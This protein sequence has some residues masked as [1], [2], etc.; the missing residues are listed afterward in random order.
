M[1]FQ[2]LQFLCKALEIL[3][4]TLQ[5]VKIIM[6]SALPI[7]SSAPGIKYSGY[8]FNIWHILSSTLSD[9][10]ST[11]SIMSSVPGIMLCTWDVLSS[12]V[13]FMSSTWD[14]MLSAPETTSSPPSITSHAPGIMSSALN[15]MSST[16]DNYVKQS[17]YYVKCSRFYAKYLRWYVIMS[18]A[19][20]MLSAPGIM[21]VVHDIIKWAYDIKLRTQNCF[22]FQKRKCAYSNRYHH[23]QQTYTKS[24]L[25]T[26]LHCTCTCI[27]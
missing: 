25:H 9:V 8:Y 2:C 7:L 14:I 20:D 1:F 3:G 24:C 18:S 19:C 22:C 27:L 4:Q 15:I 5:T 13:D 6:S 16:Q 10:S 23:I 26:P 21:L 12:P 17:K 11:C